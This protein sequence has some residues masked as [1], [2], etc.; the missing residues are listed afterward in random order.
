MGLN[1]WLVLAQHYLFAQRNQI[2][3]KLCSLRAR[4]RARPLSSIRIRLSPTLQLN[5]CGIGVA[6]VNWADD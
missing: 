5:T 4:A 1:L 6:A 3:S 2:N